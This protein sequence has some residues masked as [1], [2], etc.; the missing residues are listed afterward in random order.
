M[1][2]DE[3]SLP[4]IDVLCATLILLQVLDFG[5]TCFLLT[6]CD[7][8]YEA[9]FLMRKVLDRSYLLAFALKMGVTILLVMVVSL[10]VRD[11]L[12]LRLH[13]VLAD[14]NLK[15]EKALRLDKLNK[16]TLAFHLLLFCNAFY[17][18]VVAHN[19]VM[20]AL[21]LIWT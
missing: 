14:L 8:A 2:G 6:N 4:L 12:R 5:T 3:P 16:R 13:G 15:L 10:W 19:A 9:N 21:F 17:I 1:R 7:F 18:F 20:I 11:R